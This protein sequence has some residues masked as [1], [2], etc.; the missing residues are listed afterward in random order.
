M[1]YRM[2]LRSQYQRF[3]RFRDDAGIAQYERSANIVHGG[4]VQSLDH[5]LWADARRIAHGNTDNGTS[6]TRS[7]KLPIR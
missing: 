2:D 6:H 3:R 4:I 5:N 7:S 1:G